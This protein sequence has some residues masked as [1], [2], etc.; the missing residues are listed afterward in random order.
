VVPGLPPTGATN[1]SK[2]G[3]DA[4]AGVHWNAQPMFHVPPAMVK[5]GLVQLPDIWVAG[6]STVAGPTA[7]DE[8]GVEEPVAPPV[9]AVVD[10]LPAAVVVVDPLDVP[11]AAPGDLPAAT[12]VDVEEPAAGGSVPLVPEPVPVLLD[13]EPVS[14]L[15]AIP[16]T[17]ATTIAANSCQ[18]FQV[19]RSLIL[20]SPFSG[21]YDRARR[22]SSVAPE[23][24]VGPKG[25]TTGPA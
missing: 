8:V 7:A 13:A 2:E 15:M 4:G 23:S 25:E 3:P 24:T 5:A 18:V 6:M 9:A 17:A 12:V 14:P 1:T 16:A 21:W 20:S 11:A 22:G 19:R 10:V